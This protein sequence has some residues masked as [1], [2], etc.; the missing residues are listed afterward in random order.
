M[1]GRKGGAGKSPYLSWGL[2]VCLWKKLGSRPAR[3]DVSGWGPAGFGV[4]ALPKSGRRVGVVM[5]GHRVGRWR[6]L[7]DGQRVGSR[8]PRLCMGQRR[9]FGGGWG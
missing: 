1:R 8:C 7:L 4:M 3:E 6:E 2:M 9:G 5:L